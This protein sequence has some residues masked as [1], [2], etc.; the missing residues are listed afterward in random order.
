MSD[1]SDES[2][3]KFE[4]L[5]FDIDNRESNWK[6][7][8]HKTKD[9]RIIKLTEMTDQHIKYTI[10]YFSQDHDTSPLEQELNSRNLQTK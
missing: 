3:L 5:M 7:G 10:R 1:Y 4:L 8:F 2:D 9:D 6:G